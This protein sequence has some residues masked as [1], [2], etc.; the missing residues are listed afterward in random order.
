MNKDKTLE[1][2]LWSIAFPGFG[3][4]LNKQMTKGFVFIFLEILINVFSHFNMAILY[5]FIGD[6]E[7]AINITNYQ[8]LM[9][10][11]CVYMYA[12]WDAYKFSHK[13]EETKRYIYLPLAFAAYFVTIGLMYSYTIKIFG[14]LLGPVWLPIL[15]LFPGLGIGYIIRAIILRFRSE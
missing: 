14:V 4:L 10:Y 11:P 5:S 2:V 3:Q 8:W 7:G 9:F 12:I 15:F 1:V 13:G 6:I